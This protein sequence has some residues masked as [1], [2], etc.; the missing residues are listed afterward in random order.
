MRTTTVEL[1][2]GCK[3]D[4]GKQITLVE[5]RKLDGEDEDMILDKEELRKGGILDKLLK[6]C[7]VSVEGNS[8]R[9]YIDKLYDKHF[10][11]A[12]SMALLVELR[13]WSIDTIYRFEMSCPRCD[14]GSAHTID[15]SSLH[16]DKQKQE[17][18]FVEEFDAVLEASN[19]FLPIRFRLLKVADNAML[20]VIRTEFKKERGTRELLL[21]LKQID[22]A[23][24][25]AAAVKKLPWAMRNAA[26]RLI[27]SYTGGVD[28]ELIMDCPKCDR[29]YKE[30][31]PIDIKSFFY[32]AGDSLPTRTAIPFRD[33]GRTQSTSPTATVGV[34]AKSAS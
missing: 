3:D 18:R 9:A 15:L 22:G 1:P 12:D 23:E 17:Y 11:L 24:V 28:N 32:P 8:D 20:D 21:Q 30:S 26:R 14:H 10:L 7:I 13:K 31:M 4:A 27:D 25:T 34:Q 19:E 16:V 2:N 29:T 33:Y 5:L 6:R